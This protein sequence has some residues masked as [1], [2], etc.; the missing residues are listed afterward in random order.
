[1]KKKSRCSRP[2]F[3][4]LFIVFLVFGITGGFPGS[5]TGGIE[6]GASIVKT[7][8]TDEDSAPAG[9][10]SFNQAGTSGSDLKLW[11]RQPAGEWTD[12][13][14]IGNG[15]LGAM[16]FGKIHKERIQLNEESVWSGGPFQRE[17]KDAW[18]TLSEVRELLFEE[19]YAEAEDL[20]QEKMMA[21][22]LPGGVHTYQ[23]L[24]DL[25]LEFEHGEETGL[26]IRELD[27][28]QAIARVQ[29]QV[30]EKNYR[31]EIFSSPV[32]QALLMR[33]T[34]DKPGNITVT[35]ALSRPKDA[36]IC[37]S[38]P[39]IIMK[40]LTSGEPRGLAGFYGVRYETQLEVMVRG[41]HL[42]AADGRI[43]VQAADEVILKLVAATNYRGDNPHDVCEN[44]L[45][46]IQ[47]KSW[48]KMKA[49]HIDEHQRLFRRVRLDLCGSGDQDLPTDERLARI[50]TGETDPYLMMLYFQFGRYLLISS[51]R[52]GGLPANLQGIW[53]GTLNPPWN[54]D[55]HININLQMNYWPAEVTNLSECHEPL[56][57]FIERL[58]VRGRETA[59]NMYNCRGWVAHHTS[60]A[61]HFTSPIGK[62]VWGMWPMGGAWCCQHLWEHYAFTGDMDFLANMAYP[63]MK[64]AALFFTDYLVENP[65]TG[66][67][68]TGP[69][70]SPENRFRTKTGRIS[71]MAMGPTMDIQ[72]VRDLFTNCIESSL[73]LNTDSEFRNQLESLSS[74]L[75]PMQIGSDGRL[76]EW[77]EEYEEPEPGHRHISHLFGMHPGRQI[78]MDRS[79][80]L[81]AA[82]RKTIEY[83]LSHGGGHTGWSRA[84]IVNFFARLLDAEKAHE[85]LQALLRKSTLT[86]LFDTH[87]PFQIDGNFGGTAGIAEM[88]LQSHQKDEDGNW[89]I[90]LLP[91][92]PSAWEEGS[93]TGLKT[94]GGFEADLVWKYGKLEKVILKSEL[95]NTCVVKSGQK[96]KTATQYKVT[97]GNLIRFK[98]QPG[99]SYTI[100]SDL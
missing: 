3:S 33:L 10:G 90:H 14:P 53:E 70:N 6:A 7:L 38:G 11:Y 97:K 50:K 44:R 12:A 89:I 73:I 31:R 54:A 65:K 88:L 39:R 28:D 56:F 13:L 22:R 15:S 40:G 27:L 95:G 35:A 78:T 85:N 98:T 86:N 4:L 57:S 5:P 46:A 55:Y 83:R 19:K 21:M 23:T 61:W 81:A 25:S 48:N 71:Q 91:A 99:Q 72:I 8:S 49:D 45:A 84:W 17:R 18:K 43:R 82:A 87:P 75:Q 80:E 37:V 32:D 30:G 9:E 47:T 94:R 76:F 51:S 52:P 100:V 16:V 59:K 24:G 34:C 62:P 74:R 63:I 36:E 1:M 77:S 64:E 60:D 26:F 67:L 93:V 96:L 69:S 2:V 29:Y 20:V 66:Y 58:R 41:G 42:S 92:L 79:P 68:T